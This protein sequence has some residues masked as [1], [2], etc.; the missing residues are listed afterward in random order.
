MYI[1]FGQAPHLGSVKNCAPPPD[2][3]GASTTSFSADS[4]SFETASFHIY[5]K[6]PSSG[7]FT[8]ATMVP[9]MKSIQLAIEAVR[10]LPTSTQNAPGTANADAIFDYDQNTYGPNGF[11]TS[12]NPHEVFL[13]LTSP[14][15]G[16]SAPNINFTGDSSKSGGLVAP[17]MA[18]SGLSRA[19][20]TVSG[21]TAPGSN[22]YTGGLD[23]NDFF[24]G[25]NPM[26][27]GFVPLKSIIQT[28]TS[29][30]AQFLPKTV[31]QEIASAEAFLQKAM[32][33][34]QT[35]QNAVNRATE[36]ATQIQN[37]INSYGQLAQ[38]IVPPN[39]PPITAA[40]K[41]AAAAAQQAA[42]TA[43]K[44]VQDTTNGFVAQ[45]TAIVND[46]AALAD[47]VTSFDAQ[48][49]LV[50]NGSGK[51]DLT[52]FLT[53]ISSFL[54]SLAPTGLSSLAQSL[55]ATNAAQA[56]QSAASYMNGLAAQVQKATNE[57]NS[58]ITAAQGATQTAAQIIQQ[59]ESDINALSQGLELA[60]NLSVEL[61]WQP[62]IKSLAVSNVLAFVP[63]TDQALTLD[64]KVDAHSNT[65]LAG[66]N[67][68][69]RL[70]QFAIAF[71]DIPSTLGV[72][73][74]QVTSTADVSLVFDHMQIQ[75]DAGQKPS[76][77][78]V[79][80]DIYFAGDLAFVET[81]KNLLPLDA[82]SD[83][84]FVTLTPSGI[85]AGFNLG[86]PNI[87]IGMFSIQNINISA[88]LT[89]PFLTVTTPTPGQ[90][91]GV[92]FEFDFCTMDN[93][94]VVTVCMLG[95]GGFF[96]MSMDM[97]GLTRVQFGIEV[98]A[99]LAF[100][101]TIASGSISIEVGIFMVYTKYAEANDPLTQ[102]A[103]PAN[104]WVFGGY[105]RLRGELD[106]CGI[107]SISVELYLQITY[108]AT[109]ANA[110]KCVASG[111]IA[112]DVHLLFFSLDAQIPF[113]RT[114]AGSNGDPTFVQMMAAGG[115]VSE[116]DPTMNP[117]N[118]NSDQ[119]DP[120]AEYCMAYA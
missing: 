74:S 7:A 109:G 53:A 108:T 42:Q 73:V 90:P 103:E 14:L 88:S 58:F 54:N 111:Y 12:S 72:G 102:Q 115:A 26:L 87:A 56:A 99:Q 23:P 32:A 48:K 57:V 10:H 93:P 29:G 85:T 2:G 9:W 34:Y 13:T 49:L 35:I 114:F 4:T 89:V 92:S 41:A 66:A 67:I 71:G 107:I 60:K 69:C 50:D 94:F 75:L 45:L 5:L 22:L 30:A 104:S 120:F 117:A 21:S 97:T 101:V 76:V 18:I 118:A 79:F 47:D 61:K 81:I 105:L 39:Q 52:V 106:I 91:T 63:Q 1:W 55:G 3:A 24:S 46:G 86:I 6:T 51:S 77:D 68:T 112:V 16:Q 43:L 95:G 110:G 25:F 119:W 15:S 70:D 82:F 27:F 64:V 80:K 84:P 78:V 28:V 11:N 36:I 37:D 33:L 116:F 19:H 65:G 40:Q 113:Q 83:P 31:T 8:T 44:M 38:G 100:D 17:A 59:L 20:G 62:K 98:S 96:G